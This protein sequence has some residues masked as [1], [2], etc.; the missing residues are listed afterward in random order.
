MFEAMIIKDSSESHKFENEL[1]LAIMAAAVLLLSSSF[2]FSGLLLL[3]KKVA[4]W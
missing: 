3:R 1:N 2:K 4:W